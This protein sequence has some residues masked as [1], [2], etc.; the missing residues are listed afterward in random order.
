MVTTVCVTFT[1]LCIRELFIIGGGLA[2]ILSCGC[3]C[4]V[5]RERYVVV[6]MV[7]VVCVWRGRGFGSGGEGVGHIAY[8]ISGS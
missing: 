5:N 7:V 2:Y 8:K 3:E 6:L 4:G 1:G